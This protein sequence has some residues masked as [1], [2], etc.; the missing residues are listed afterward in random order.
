M[1]MNVCPIA[2]VHA[3]DAA[4]WSLLADPASYAKWWDATTDIISPTGPAQPGQLIIAHSQ[5]LG[6]RWQVCIQV[7]SIDSVKRELQ[8]TTTLPLG[9]T[10]INHIVVR[11]L[12]PNSCC[13][14]FG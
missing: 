11:G 8:L 14:S 3:S 7:D 4:V 13:V 9:I 5:A 6:R 12:N 1:S 2:T 10:V